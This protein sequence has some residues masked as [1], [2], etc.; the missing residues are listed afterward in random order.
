MSDS[1]AYKICPKS[2]LAMVKVQKRLAIWEKYI[3]L[4]TFPFFG[5]RIPFN[6]I[7]LECGYK[8]GG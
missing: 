8:T 6:G 5:E 2:T 3:L 1:F 7:I 4:D